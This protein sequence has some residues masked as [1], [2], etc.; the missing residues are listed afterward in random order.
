MSE[1]GPTKLRLDLEAMGFN[2]EM[3]TGGDQNT[4]AIMCKYEVQIG[5][6]A[7]RIIDLA[8]MATSDY[9]RSIPSALH[10]RAHPQL[11]EKSDTVANVRNITD[12]ALGT[13]WRY[14]SKNFGWDGERTTRRL[15]SQI[16]KV[17]NDA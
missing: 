2:V 13:E 4:Y 10:V 6:F 17:F 14:W 7:G 15:I 3:V 16:N 12:S 11:F 1:Y 8:I 9:P 5:R